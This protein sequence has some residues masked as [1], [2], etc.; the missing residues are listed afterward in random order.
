MTQM[1]DICSCWWI[2]VVLPALCQ[3]LGLSGVSD[4]LCK[5]SV[6]ISGYSLPGIALAKP[7]A[8]LELLM[9]TH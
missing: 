9:F 8:L 4:L 7:H 3:A 5:S 2:D 1:G 6:L